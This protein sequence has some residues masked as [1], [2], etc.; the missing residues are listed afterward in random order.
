MWNRRALCRLGRLCACL[1]ALAA[2]GHARA[3]EEAADDEIVWAVADWP[4]IFI[5]P[6]G[7]A[8]ASPAAL[9][10]GRADLAM[11]ELIKRLPGYRHRFE[12]V[13]PRRMWKSFADG[14]RFC[15]AVTLLT[16]ER[17]KLAYF[18]PLMLAPPMA[19]AVRTDRRPAGFGATGVS[20]QAVVAQ[21]GLSGVVEVDRSYGEALDRILDAPPGVPRHTVS[22]TGQLVP[23]VGAGRYDYTLEYPFV[24]AYL[25]RQP[26]FAYPVESVSL[27]ESR[28]WLVSHVAC[29]RGEWGRRVMLD[30]DAAI[31]E[32]AASPALR[33]AAEQWL[34]ESV[35]DGPRAERF[36]EERAR[37]SYPP[38]GAPVR[39]KP[40]V[41]AQGTAFLAP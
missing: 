4:P 2:L 29:T 25:Q 26:G 14:H 38:D 23:L 30:I 21:P 11:A 24:V 10:D 34:P 17:Q 37:T 20:L 28:E 39:P 3:A 13:M 41:G 8:P 36:F 7:R 40:G 1:C 16:P 5:L 22:R 6:Q 32:A 35:R 27:A 33:R 31:R 19:L 15:H 9:G 18:S 12:L